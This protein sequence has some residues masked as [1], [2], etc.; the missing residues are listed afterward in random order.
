MILYGA[1]GHAKVVYDCLRSI[2]I[3]ICGVFDDDQTKAKFLDR[4]IWHQYDRELL[5]DEK[6]IICIGDNKFRY[7]LA[8]EIKHQPG[9]AVHRQSYISNGAAVG[10]GSVVMAGVLLPSGCTIGNFSIINT[11]AIVEHDCRIGDFVH[12]GSGAVVCGGVQI[13]EG[14]L[15]GANATILPGVSIGSWAI[16]GAGSVVN[17]DIPNGEKVAGN[18]A[19]SI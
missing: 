5:K 7:K 19:R 11:G 1:G 6:I 4:A 9:M 15:I 12:I 10:A 16:V 8:G 13:G 2:N 18:P 3:D 14:A 17:K